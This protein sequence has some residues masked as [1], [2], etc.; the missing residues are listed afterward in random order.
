MLW[1]PLSGRG[2]CPMQGLV[3]ADDG[4]KSNSSDSEFP[5][6]GASDPG[7]GGPAPLG[8]DFQQPDPLQQE[9]Q[10][11][12]DAAA[13]AG[14]ATYTAPATGCAVMTAGTLAARGHCCGNG[15]RHC[16]FPPAEQ[17]RA[18]RPGSAPTSA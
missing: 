8:P 14:M 13:Q 16:P 11:R 12:H 10:S 4:S 5:E 3:R 2:P 6:G 17:F 15:C 9:L 1:S 18:G 7:R